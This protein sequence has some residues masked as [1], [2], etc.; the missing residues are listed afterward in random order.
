M[1]APASLRK[2]PLVEEA[3]A[4]EEAKLALFSFDQGDFA[5]AVEIYARLVKSPQRLRERAELH[6]AHLHFAFS[7]FLLSQTTEAQE[8]LEIALQLDPTYELSPVLTRPDLYQFYT[9]ARTVWVAEHGEVPAR[10]G[11][12]F[13]DLVRGPVEERP[14]DFFPMFGTGLWYHGH[15]E[16]GRALRAAEITALSINLASILFRL[17]LITDMTPNGQAA[18]S[19]W[20]QV[21]YVSAPFCWSLF[22]LDVV[23]SAVVHEDARRRSYIEDVP[24]EGDARPRPR[25]DVGVGGFTL[26]W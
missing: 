12:V 22:T 18:T 24:K 7:Q 10:L 2:D 9:Q 21:T 20:R 19:T 25:L 13:P 15:E 8:L 26:R 14:T 1:A 5:R 3:K 11:A 4:R 6:D 23:A 17:A 16:A